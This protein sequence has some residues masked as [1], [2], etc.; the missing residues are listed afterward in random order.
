MLVTSIL[1]A[2]YGIIIFY[3]QVQIERDKKWDDDDDD[4][5]DVNNDDNDGD[6]DRNDD[7]CHNWYH[8]HHHRYCQLLNITSVNITKVLCLCICASV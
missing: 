4:D 7:D 3:T 6:D 8:H 1:P 2:Y 5:D